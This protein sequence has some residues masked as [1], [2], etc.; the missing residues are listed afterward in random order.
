MLAEPAS[1]QLHFIPTQGDTEK[2]RS[3]GK[4]SSG[5]SFK[6]YIWL[7]TIWSVRWPEVQ[8]QTNSGAVANDLTGWLGT[9]EMIGSTL[10][11]SIRKVL[12]HVTARSQFANNI[13]LFFLNGCDKMI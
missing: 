9:L 10:D 13:I 1:G 7:F 2:D 5:H 12:G 8:I 4:S 6:Q 11:L 3:K